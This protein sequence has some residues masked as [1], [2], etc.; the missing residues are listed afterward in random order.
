MSSRIQNLNV[1]E[2]EEKGRL[3]LYNLTQKQ[4]T[5]LTPKNLVVTDFKPYPTGDRILFAASDWS[6]Y[7]P[8]LFEQQLYTV[9]TGLSG[10]SATQP[11][12]AQK[13]S[14]IDRIL[15]NFDYQNLKFDL[16]PDGQVIVVERVNRRNLDDSGLWILRAGTPWQPLLK[17]PGG[18]FLIAPDSATLANTQGEGVAILPLTPQAKPLDF[19]PKFNKVLSF[20]RIGVRAAMVKSNS[21]STQSLFLVTNQGLE[22]ELLRTNGEFLNCQFGPSPQN[23]YCLMAQLLQGEEY[24]QQL[25]VQAIDLKTSKVESLLVLSSQSEVQMS[26]SP[27]GLSLLLDRVATKETLPSKDDFTTDAG[28]AIATSRLWFV[29][30]VN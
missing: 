29:P 9:T 8:G 13:A 25:S 17:Q 12:S 14:R 18:E 3:I 19:L 26:L 30:L 21:D 20:D 27:D 7:R 28:A 4:K 23:L 10:N 5:L 15:D 1:F 11:N 24:S 22:K 16:S 2:G 6:N